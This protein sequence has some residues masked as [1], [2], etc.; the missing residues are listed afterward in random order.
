[1]TRPP[2]GFKRLL[3]EYKH[4]CYQAAFD[5]AV[6]LA[7]TADTP[8]VVCHGTI[9]G[10]HA[11]KGQRIPHAWVEVEDAVFDWAATGME[12]P[13]PREDYYRI[14]KP[15]SVCRYSIVEVVTFL[16]ELDHYGPWQETIRG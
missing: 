12:E 6:E 7:R 4:R 1:M 5:A 16:S 9:D 8:P 14:N 13:I 11:Y 2:L 10:T 15:E 3:T